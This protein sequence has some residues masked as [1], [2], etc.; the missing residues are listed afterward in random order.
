MDYKKIY[1][2][3]Y[4]GLDYKSAYGIGREYKG[5]LSSGIYLLG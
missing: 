3:N 2:Q 4:L 5:F 1:S